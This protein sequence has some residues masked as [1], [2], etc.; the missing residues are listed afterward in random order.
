[1]CGIPL[2]FVAVIHVTPILYSVYST[3]QA[4]EKMAEKQQGITVTLH[5][6]LE[7][8]HGQFYCDQVLDRI[9]QIRQISKNYV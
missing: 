8:Y 6:K 5:W 7:I 1:M 2:D 9:K 4:H 3:A